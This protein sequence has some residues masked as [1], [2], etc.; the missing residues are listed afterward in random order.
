MA[1]KCRLTVNGRVIE[2]NVGE[3]LVDAALGGWTVIPHDCCSG[4]CETC[5]VNVLSGNID[6][7]GT[8]DGSTVL[9]CTATIEGDAE[10]E[11]DEIPRTSSRSGLLTNI[12][13]LAP[14]VVEITVTLNEPIAYRPG[15]YLNVKFSGFPGRDLSQTFRSDGTCGENELIFQLR[16]YPGGLVSTQIGATIGIGHRVSVRGPFGHAFLRDG[17]GP[18]VLISGGT[19]WAPIWSLAVEARRRQASR[20]L[21]VIAGARDP[22]S[23]YMRDSLEWLIDQGVQNVI[24]VCEMGAVPPLRLGLPTHYLPLL[25][26]DDT[27]YVAG[28]VPLVDAVRIKSRQARARCYADPFIPDA[29]KPSLLDRLT[30][31]LQTGA[32]SR[33]RVAAS[34][35]PPSYEPVY[36]E[37]LSTRR[38]ILARGIRIEPK[39]P[40]KPEGGSRDQSGSPKP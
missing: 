4:Q 1:S 40:S 38:P 17:D 21:I 19:G 13:N 9:A 28:P 30:R 25:G 23:L 11:F 20:E 29:R 31:L 5:R 10:I 32:A 22:S 16:R 3:T 18:I 27:V 34:A 35:R 24:G 26:L 6:D 39:N 36:A 12:T 8:L 2:A 37:D 7:Q 33:R 15:Q 14:D